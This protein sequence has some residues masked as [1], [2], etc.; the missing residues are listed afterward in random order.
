MAQHQIGVHTWSHPPMT[1]I[2]TEGIIA[3]LGWA[4]KV[5]KDIL[6]VTPLQWRPPYGDIDNRVR[7]IATAMGL[8]TVLWTRISPTATFDTNDYNV[9]G[10]SVSAS[11]VLDN[12]ESIIGNATVIDTGFIVL[13]HDLFVQTVELATGYILPAALANNPKFD[14]KPVINCMKKPISDA[15]LETNDNSSNPLPSGTASNVPFSSG[16]PGSAQASGGA[17]GSGGAQKPSSAASVSV[18]GALV[19]AGSVFVALFAGFA[20]LL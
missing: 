16:A 8:E 9:A 12:W 5:I 4:K 11:Q 6:G 17:N 15:Y 2:T 19:A 18:S 20:V 13:E 3:E 10:G 7:A 14:I 1:T